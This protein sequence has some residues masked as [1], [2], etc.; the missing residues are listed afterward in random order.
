MKKLNYF[1]AAAAMLFMGV[2]SASAQGLYVKP[3]VG[4]G[5]AATSEIVGQEITNF[6]EEN[7][8]TANNY[9]TFGGGLNGRLGIG[10]M[11]NKHVGLELG[12]MYVLGST[13]TTDNISVGDSYDDSEAKAKR[14]SALPSLVVDAGLEKISPYAR[15]G[16]TIPLG[17]G[18]D[19]LRES[20]DPALVSSVIPLL[21]PEAASFKAVSLANGQ[22]G[23]GFNSA[24]GVNY[25]ISDKMAI[26][27]EIFYEAL[28]I[29]RGTY[30]VSE[31]TLTLTDGTE[32][33]VLAL[34]S[35][36]GAF[37]YTE[38]FHE[39]KADELAAH[40]QAAAEAASDNPD[41]ATYYGTKDYPAWD[42]VQDVNFSS[43]GFNL[44][45]KFSFGGE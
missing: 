23:I 10:Y 42:I 35:L 32:E 21:Y 44:G 36:G 24:F 30:E 1:F 28:R 27:G 3:S 31:A 41:V 18:T 2:S 26:F 4:F 19:G 15:F 7:Q 40:Q 20:N 8:V 5:M 12:F 14:Y 43:F 45:V 34:L 9:N 38:Y 39:I 25:N 16:L 33:D 13:V 29:K 6:G 17:G 22:F 37:P 11:F